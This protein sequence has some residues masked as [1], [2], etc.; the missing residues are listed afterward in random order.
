MK[1]GLGDWKPLTQPPAEA[2]AGGQLTPTWRGG[3]PVPGGMALPQVAAP[4]G[5]AVGEGWEGAWK[6]LWKWSQD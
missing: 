4:R 5:G 3:S 6:G 1:G 2:A